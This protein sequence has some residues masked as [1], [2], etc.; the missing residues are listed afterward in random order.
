[1]MRRAT[2]YLDPKIHRAVKLKAVETETTM[3]DLVN[4]A[5]RH[6]LKEDVIDLAAIRQRAHEST[7]SFEEVIRD[8]KRDGLL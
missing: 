4:E 6:S 2:V 1:M 3:S 8:L 5:L 7:R